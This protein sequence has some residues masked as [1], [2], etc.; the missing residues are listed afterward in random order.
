MLLVTSDDVEHNPLCKRIF[1]RKI[2]KLAKVQSSKRG[3]CM[4]IKN[5]LF[6]NLTFKESLYDTF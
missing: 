2:I 3:N 1:F 4:K 6:N 5:L